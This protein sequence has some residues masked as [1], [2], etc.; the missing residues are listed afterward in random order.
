M[1]YWNRKLPERQAVQMPERSRQKKEQPAPALSSSLHSLLS[2]AMVNELS[3]PEMLELLRDLYPFASPRDRSAIADILGYEQAAKTLAYHSIRPNLS[4][5]P[6]NKRYLTAQD[7][8]LGMMKVFQKYNPSAASGFHQLEKILH[9]QKKLSRLDPTRPESMLSLLP[10][11][12]G[13]DMSSMEPMLNMIK[14]M[15][16]KGD[17]SDVLKKMGRTFGGNQ[18][19]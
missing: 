11:L 18:E 16:T 10:L 19:K 12:G 3:Q 5:P 4:G 1:E 9:M 15:S 14:N 7:R 6:A 17:I 13:P 8:M 2:M